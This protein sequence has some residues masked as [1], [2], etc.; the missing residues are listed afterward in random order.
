[1]TMR[2]P[3]P[4]LVGLVCLA[5][6]AAVG[7]GPARGGQ[8]AGRLA[9][10]DKEGRPYS[11]E[12]DPRHA[13]VYFEPATAPPVRPARESVEMTTK[14][15]EFR[16][17][18][19]PVPRGSTVRFPNLDPILHNVFSVSG[20]NRFD[21]GLYSKGPGKAWTFAAA[22][23]V[24]VFCNVHHQ[25]VGYVLVLDTQHFAAADGEG[26]FTLSGLPDGGGKVTAWHP[27]ADLW[28][29]E[30]QHGASAPLAVRLAITRERVPPHLNKFG[31]AYE[32]SRRDRY[33]G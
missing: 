19:L 1:M 21:L 2:I 15:K 6:L 18:V 14:G 22:G 32:R 30:L 16:P 25:M 17:L 12:V 5:G 29:A 3:S 31:K 13:V 4:A 7:A 11:G 8:L 23:V 10:V 27:Q 26:R 28:T 9:F 33:D 24:R 20:G